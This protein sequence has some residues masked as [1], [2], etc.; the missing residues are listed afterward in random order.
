MAVNNNFAYTF[1]IYS[2]FI[3]L[4]I[5]LHTIDIIIKVLAQSGIQSMK[6]FSVLFLLLSRESSPF[7]LENGI[8]KILR[9]VNWIG[10]WRKY[11]LAYRIRNIE[12]KVNIKMFLFKDEMSLLYRFLFIYIYLP[13]ITLNYVLICICSGLEIIFRYPHICN[14]TRI[15]LIFWPN[16]SIDCFYN[17]YV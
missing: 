16:I 12:A 11:S 3:V 5:H 6:I 10:Y 7:L 13:V 8:Q 15:E 1:T 9:C 17:V 2:Y 4:D 14:K